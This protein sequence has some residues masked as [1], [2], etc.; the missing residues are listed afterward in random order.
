VAKGLTS[1]AWLLAL[2]KLKQQLLKTNQSESEVW[3]AMNW[4]LQNRMVFSRQSFC[5]ALFS[6]YVERS[7]ERLEVVGK[8]AI[9]NISGESCLT[10][11]SRRSRI[12]EGSRAPPKVPP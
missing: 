1:I 6:K 11:A 12:R 7:Y 5:L 3:Q 2:A 10:L 8:P 4:L 9:D